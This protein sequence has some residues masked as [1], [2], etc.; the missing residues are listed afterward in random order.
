MKVQAL[1]FAVL[2]E[3]AGVRQ[4]TVELPEGATARDLWQ[5]LPAPVRE[6]GI[7]EANVRVAVNRSY[8]P[9]ETRLQ[10]GDEVAF[11]PPV[12]GGNGAGHS[13]LLA[14]PVQVRLTREPLSTED[15]VQAVGGP[16]MGAIALFVG[17]V[18]QRT[19]QRRTLRILYE[20]YDEMATA[21]LERIGQE[22]VQRYPECRVALVHRVGE[23]LPGEVS[24]V[25]AV[26][27]P[28]RAEAFAALR[29]AVE[30]VK[31]RVPIWK[32]E[33]FEDGEEWVGMGA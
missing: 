33:R 29:Q 23:L 7:T 12:A 20:A 24:L 28:H 10:E 18:R 26:A 25:V 31:A 9:W 19:G 2:A 1:L 22:L 4:L 11:I 5:R 14:P 17:T 27:C 32:K 21:E 30:A 16:E 15:W 6:A 8:A 3:R 13:R